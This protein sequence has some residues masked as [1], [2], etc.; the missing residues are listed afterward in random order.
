MAAG[1][2]QCQIALLHDCGRCAPTTTT[3]T[4]RTARAALYARVS[5][6][7]QSPDLQL[8]SLRAYIGAR[9]WLAT[10]YVDHGISGAK[11]R[12]PGLDALLEAARRRRIDVVVAVKLDRLA[13]ST[14]HLVVLAKEL[15]ALG[16]DLVIT[17]QAI[18]TTTPT[19]RL[20][21]HMLAAISEFERELIRERVIAGVRRAKAKGKKLGRP[22]RHIVDT[23]RAVALME[24]GS[25]LRSTARALGVHPSAIVRLVRAA[26]GAM[27][28]AES[29]LPNS[30]PDRPHH[31]PMPPQ[32]SG[33]SLP[34]GSF[35][36]GR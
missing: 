26:D 31:E 9:G 18:D 5:T 30:Q 22:R 6:T 14:H 35:L 21:F 33:G 24:A 3:G 1:L 25:S 28:R 27:P 23:A 34:A 8:E 20:L 16:V 17:D 2:W 13:R 4:P 10:E 32:R 19:G 29:A 12:R 15:E 7:D 11:D 36:Y